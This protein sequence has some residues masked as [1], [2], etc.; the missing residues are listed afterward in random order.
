MQRWQFKR[1]KLYF[2]LSALAPPHN[3]HLILAMTNS[4]TLLLGREF[5]KVAAVGFDHVAA[6]LDGVI[7]LQK[8]HT[9][10]RRIVKKEKCPRAS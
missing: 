7:H 6:C 8:S 9:H 3:H 4:D 5:T 2:E 10:Q 1:W